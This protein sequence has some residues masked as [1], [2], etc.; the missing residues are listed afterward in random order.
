MKTT[1]QVARDFFKV[2]FEV[3]VNNSSRKY[4]LVVVSNIKEKFIKKYPFLKYLIVTKSSIKIEKGINSVETHEIG[5]A[6]EAIINMLGPN[7]LRLLLKERLDKGD[8]SFLHN[9]GVD[10]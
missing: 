10:F 1:Q 2:I 6:I 5:K 8:K 7:L 4:G 9:V 3:L